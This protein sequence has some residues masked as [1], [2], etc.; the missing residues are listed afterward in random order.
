MRIAVGVGRDMPL[1]LHVLTPERV[2]VLVER[3][4]RGVILPDV[5]E[6]FWSDFKRPA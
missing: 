6:G 3:A 4:T 2:A 5:V 1:A